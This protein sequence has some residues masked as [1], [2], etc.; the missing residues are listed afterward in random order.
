MIKMRMSE[1]NP[2]N[3][4]AELLGGTKDCARRARE[5]RIDQRQAVILPHKEAIHHAESRQP[6]EAFGLLDNFLFDFYF[7]GATAGIGVGAP[8]STSTIFSRCPTFS[9]ITR[10]ALILSPGFSVS[11][12]FSSA[13]R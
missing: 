4:R 3:W 7:V 8:F 9:P 5:I 11:I 6:K 10:S 1:K 12:C 13:T 2:A